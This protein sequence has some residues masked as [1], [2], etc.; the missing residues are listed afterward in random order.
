MSNLQWDHRFMD[1]AA[2]ISEWSKDPSK[3]IG[4][5]IV[6]EENRNIL[7]VGYNGFPRGI[8]DDNRLL[9]RNLKHELIVHA[10]MNAIYNAGKNGI[11]LVGS[12][13]YVYGLPVCNLCSLGII[14][15][16]IKRVVVDKKSSKNERWKESWKKSKQNFKESGILYRCI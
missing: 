5:V 11:P 16:G 4:C 1:M 8:E 15:A 9:V 10:E 3:Q 6:N 7:A 2:L 14:Q 12:T 13:I